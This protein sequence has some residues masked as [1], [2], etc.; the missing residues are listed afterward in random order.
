MLLLCFSGVKG[1]LV[2]T[3]AT[4]QHWSGGIAGHM[5][6]NYCLSLAGPSNQLVADSVYAEGRWYPLA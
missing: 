6:V 2:C 4:E 3:K 1:Q 5:G